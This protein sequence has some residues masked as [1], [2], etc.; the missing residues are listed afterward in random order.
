[1]SLR[2]RWALTLAAVVAGAVGLVA[3]GSGALT[4]RTLR[5]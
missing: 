2:L 5:A 1:M 3:V 4:A